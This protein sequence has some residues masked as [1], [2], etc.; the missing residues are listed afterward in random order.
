MNFAVFASGHGGNTQA[1]IN[2]VK[3]KKIKADLKLVFSDKADAFALKR[4]QKA[5]IPTLCL[6][7][8]DYA[9]R[10]DFDRAVL[11]HLKQHG[12]DFIAAQQLWVGD[13][14]ELPA[15]TEGEPRWL[16]IGR[17]EGEYLVGGYHQ[18]RPTDPDYFREEITP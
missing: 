9:G 12:I 6:N 17:I 1:I 2:A 11:A 8:K 7:P 4:A 5:K 10:E 16:V 13:V 15:R 18:A 3:K 14:V